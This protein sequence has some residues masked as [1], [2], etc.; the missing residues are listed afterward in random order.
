MDHSVKS[1]IRW[2]LGFIKHYWLQLGI[3][4]IIEVFSLASTL[5]FIWMSKQAIDSAQ[6][7]NAQD[8]TT[9]L[10]WVVISLITSFITSLLGNRL[11]E[12]TKAAM[13]INLQNQITSTQMNAKWKQTSDWHTGDILVRMNVDSQETIQLL[14]N[15]WISIFI[16]ILKI[17]ASISLLYWMEPLLALLLVVICPLVIL[18]KSFF[19]RLRKLTKTLKEQEGELGKVLQENFRNRLFIRSVN[20]ESVRW[21][22]VQKNQE[23]IYLK[24]L[25]LLDFSTFSKGTLG[26]VMQLSYLVT[27]IWGV[28]K[29][30]S[31]E[32]T[33]GTMS[34]FLQLVGRIQGPLITLMNYVPI[35]VRSRTSLDRV[36][37]VLQVD[38][39]ERT[40][41]DKLDFIDR[42]SLKNIT[43]R[44]NNET[45]LN[46]VN[47]EFHKGQPVAVFGPSGKGK[48][49]LLRIIM[50]L[51]PPEEGCVKLHKG[52][53]ELFMKES[54][55]CNFAYVPQG[56]K[57]L[58]G[59]IR[60]NLVL[61]HKF[62]K[63]NDIREALILAC[64]DFVFELP[65]GIDTIVGEGGYG[66]S[67]GQAQRIGIARAIL[68]GSNVWLFDEITSSLDEPTSLRLVT[69]LIEKGRDKI[70]VFVTHDKIL[71]K[72]CN[73]IYKMG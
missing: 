48:S 73:S 40:Q 33:F 8:V 4:L 37:D 71:S 7:G 22:R 10:Y 5:F 42:I 67:E 55:R 51:F 11:N 68:Q 19:K 32:I 50:G 35:L 53:L 70:V 43:F 46:D 31:S 26:I 21:D 27:F 54:Y 47:M 2:S 34:A 16:T 66:L 12:R 28:N 36:M 17:I 72:F 41:E 49:T 52:N 23:S 44:Y 9:S 58:S 57:L 69:N 39:E 15:V 38:V 59:T 45:L 14:G 6:H 30:Q 63:A 3:Y 1:H 20:W 60:E 65:N 18:S 61:S 24:K 29:L 62:H 56:D 25:K 64:A 13:L